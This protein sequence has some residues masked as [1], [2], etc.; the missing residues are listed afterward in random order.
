MMPIVP[1]TDRKVDVKHL[2]QQG[3]VVLDVRTEEEFVGFHLPGAM[4]IPFDDLDA[5]LECIRKWQ[6][7][8]IVY[9]AND[10]R[11]SLAATKLKNR[12]IFAVDGGSREELQ[13]LLK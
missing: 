12:G 9:G 13:V 7:P 2:F 4:N 6:K 5:N 8:V 3:A 1:K 11:S 10:R